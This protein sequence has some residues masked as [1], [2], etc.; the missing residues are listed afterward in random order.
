MQ[1]KSSDREVIDPVPKNDDRLGK[2]PDEL[3]SSHTDLQHCGCKTIIEMS[4]AA[5][6][7]A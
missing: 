2:I 7:T 5:T 4:A 1:Q 6:A 3:R